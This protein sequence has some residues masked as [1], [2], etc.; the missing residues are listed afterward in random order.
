MIYLDLHCVF[1]IIVFVCVSTFNNIMVTI[2]KSR[3]SVI[4]ERI[5]E[6]SEQKAREIH[7]MA[8]EVGR[9]ICAKACRL[10]PLSARC[11]VG[12]LSWLCVFVE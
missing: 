12:E 1:V 5:R 4:L 7:A 11:P 8:V 2:L 9:H 6:A 3:V 10:W